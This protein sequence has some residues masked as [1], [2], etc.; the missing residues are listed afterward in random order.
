[1]DCNNAQLRSRYRTQDRIDGL[2]GGGIN[3]FAGAGGYGV[4]HVG[5]P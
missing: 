1:M 5:S 3:R 2:P 4:T